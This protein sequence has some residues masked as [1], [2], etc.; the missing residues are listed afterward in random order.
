MNL[1]NSLRKR[2]ISSA[3]LAFYLFSPTRL[4]NSIKHEHSCKILF[5]DDGEESLNDSDDGIGDEEEEEEE[6]E[7]SSEDESENENIADFQSKLK[8]QS[9]KGEFR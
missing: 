3:S 8:L 4:I 1:L 7:E 5:V 9:T 2:D 6:L